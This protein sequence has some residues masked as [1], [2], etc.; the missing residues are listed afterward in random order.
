MI[1]AG[2]IQ[3]EGKVETKQQ[4]QEEDKTFTVKMPSVK[5]LIEKQDNFLRSWSNKD[6]DTNETNSKILDRKK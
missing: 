2:E 1:L 6:I 3:D 4:M 5:E